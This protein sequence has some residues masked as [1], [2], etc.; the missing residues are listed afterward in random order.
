MFEEI[1][2]I[3]VGSIGIIGSILCVNLL[4]TEPKLSIS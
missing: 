2:I 4:R 1:A 3:A